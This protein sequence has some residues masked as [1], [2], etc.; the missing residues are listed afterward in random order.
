MKTAIMAI[1]ALSALLAAAV[2]IPVAAAEGWKRLKGI[3]LHNAIVARRMRFADGGEQSFAEDGT[4]R[5]AGQTIEHG[6]WKTDD[7]D[8]LCQDWRPQDEWVCVKVERKED[9]RQLRFIDAEGTVTVATYLS[10]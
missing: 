1:V 4:M 8:R 6:Y 3:D 7:K 2:P 5:L 9:G 10:Y